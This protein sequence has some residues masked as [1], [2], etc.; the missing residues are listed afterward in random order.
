MKRLISTIFI[1]VAFAFPANA[2]LN[3]QKVTSPG[4]I[5]AWLVDAPSI[6]FVSLQIR[7]KG[8]TSLDLP[9]KRGAVFMM[10]GLLEEGA[11]NL[12]AEAFL[13]AREAL[14][15]SYS[16]NAD[17]DSISISARFLRSNRDAA[18]EL[19]RKAIEEPRFDPAAISRIRAQ[20]ISIIAG[21]KKDQ[22][23]IAATEFNKLAFAGSP[24]GSPS[25][26]TVKSVKGLSRKDIINAYKDTMTRDRLYV[27]AVGDISAAELGQVLDKLFSSLPAKGAP[28]PGLVKDKLTGGV[29]VIKFPS[30]QTV[31]LFGEKG[32]K[33]TDPDFFAAYVMNRIFGG[34]GF[35]SRLTKEVRVKRGLTYGVYTYLADYDLADLL[36]GSVASANDKIA[37][38]LDVIR[39]QWRKMAKS[40]ATEAELVAAKKYLT[41]AYPLRFAGN[42]R[43]ASILAGMQLVGLPAS[44]IKTRNAKINAVTLA[45]VA[46]VA[47]RLLKLKNLRFV[48]V[49]QPVGVKSTD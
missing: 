28:M 18:V 8:G 12:D 22:G 36:Q 33:R 25:T 30:P 31:A 47:K 46:R 37:E 26:G 20:V 24:Y 49:G 10:A 45:D 42:A 1:L 11:G 13:K 34:G 21:N 3:I 9:G 29:T 7:F 2:A 5:K 14:A 48:V 41:G 15:A 4:G 38:A 32:I 44:Y 19:L 43:I 23:E 39:T 16:F 17:R 40:G 6:P 35:S 27:S